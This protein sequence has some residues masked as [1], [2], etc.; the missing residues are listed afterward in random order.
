[1]LARV[2]NVWFDAAPVP[3]PGRPSPEGPPPDPSD[4]ENCRP[5]AGLAVMKQHI[6]TLRCRA[7]KSIQTLGDCLEAVRVRHHGGPLLVCLAAFVTL[8]AGE[9]GGE[10]SGPTVRPVLSA[11]LTSQYDDNIYQQNLGPLAGQTSW[12]TALE[13]VAGVSIEQADGP[14]TCALRLA[15]EADYRFFYEADSESYWRHNLAANIRVS[16]GAWQFNTTANLQFTDGSTESIIWLPPGA[17]P[18]LGAIEIRNR[19]RNLQYRQRL[20]LRRELGRFFARGV[21]DGR[22]W[23]FMTEQRDVPFYQNFVD[24]D[25]LNGGLDWGW[26]AAA[27]LEV[28]VGYRVGHQN[29]PVLPFGAPVT[30]ANTYHRALGGVNLR[31]GKRFQL[32]GEMGPSFH[33]FN[34]DTLW[35]GVAANQTLLYARGTASLFLPPHTTLRFH[36][37]QHLLPSSSGRGAFQNLRCGA[38]VEQAL[39]PRLRAALDFTLEEYDFL[40][41]TARRDRTF[42][43]AGSLDYTVSPHL[44]LGLFYSY[45]WADSLVPDTA[46]R[47]FDRHIVGGRLRAVY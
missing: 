31:A 24:R 28:F 13:P 30:Y 15:Y 17:V 3:D 25:D 10:R 43:P 33:Q 26:K 34:G 47:E 9:P 36:A 38:T 7:A 39:H 21:Y 42:T 11:A 46:A 44:S 2:P 22:L 37:G 14:V 1:M 40:P 23:D 16:S 5:P 27:P 19:R 6:H 32:A 29:Q 45:T 20:E 4:P 8:T 12:I 41:I 35:P 18:A